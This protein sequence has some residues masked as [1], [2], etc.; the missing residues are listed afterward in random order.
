VLP[1]SNKN[2]VH[3]EHGQEYNIVSHRIEVVGVQ[4]LESVGFVHGAED[5]GTGEKADES[6]R[7][8][9]DSTGCPT[10]I[11]DPPEKAPTEMVPED[12]SGVAGS[13]EKLSID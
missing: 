3:S 13:F 2:V 1:T 12:N 4:Y 6:A 7:H 8:R 9:R 11:V 5:M 10:S